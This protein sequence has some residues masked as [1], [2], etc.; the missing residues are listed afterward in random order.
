MAHTWL[1]QEAKERQ[2]AIEREEYMSLKEARLAAEA[3]VRPHHVLC[4]CVLLQL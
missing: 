2:A 4:F 1:T 3:E